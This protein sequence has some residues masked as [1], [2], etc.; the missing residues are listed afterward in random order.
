MIKKITFIPRDAENGHTHITSFSDPP[1]PAKLF[2][3]DWYRNGEAFLNKETFELT[4]VHDKHKRAGM[5]YCMPFFDAMV[6]GY[7][8]QSWVDVEVTHNSD[9]VIK[10]RYIK[11][12]EYTGKFEEIENYPNEMIFERPGDLGH[13]IPRPAGHAKNHMTLGGIWGVHVPK[14]WSVLV[15]HPMNRFDLPFTTMSGLMDSDGFTASGNIPFF[16]RD[17]WTGVIP[18]GTPFA[19]LL[20]IKRSSWVSQVDTHQKANYSQYVGRKAR[21]VQYG[22]YK[23]NVWVKKEYE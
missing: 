15:T 20:P 22:Y 2:L 8:I 5:K 21:E 3:P 13:T 7:M 11:E 14:N 10:W 12:N 19:Q 4:D 6:S 9:N 18:K 1:Q 23:Q 17:G 16:F